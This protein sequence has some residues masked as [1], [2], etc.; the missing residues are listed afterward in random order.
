MLGWNQHSLQII[1][2]LDHY[3]PSGSEL[4]IASEDFLDDMSFKS[5]QGISELSLTQRVQQ[6]APNLARLRLETKV[7]DTTKVELLRV[8]DP[9]SFDSI[10]LL[11]N[12]VI[13][14]S[15]SDARTIVTLLHLRSL[16]LESGREF[17]IVCELRDVRDEQLVHVAKPDDYIIG[18]KIVAM[19]L[20]QISENRHLADI[21]EELFAQRGSEIYL[22]PA[23]DYIEIGDEVDFHAVVYAD[24]LK[25]ETAIG[26]RKAESC[27]DAAS[28]FGVHFN[29]VKSKKITFAPRDK[30]IVLA[31]LPNTQTL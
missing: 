7:I 5:S 30:I 12:P 24:A 21:F 22:N 10:I 16:Q 9:T 17:R 20:A 25:G 18:E 6:I 1:S 15:A 31:E 8:L 2:E 29:P 23:E 28:Q 4:L 19:L 26:Y 14:I 27:N 11:C 13:D 3:V